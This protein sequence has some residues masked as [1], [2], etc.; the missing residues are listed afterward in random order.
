MNLIFKSPEIFKGANEAV[1]LLYNSHIITNISQKAAEQCI[2]EI[3]RNASISV[4]EDDYVKASDVLFYEYETEDTEIVFN[5]KKTKE[6]GYVAVEFFD[7]RE[8]KKA[9][10]VISQNFELLG[11]TREKRRLTSFQSALRPAAGMLWVLL[12]GGV[13][14]WLAYREQNSPTTGKMPWYIYIFC[15][16]VKAAGYLP[17]AFITAVLLVICFEWMFKRLAKPV[18]NI[19]A[20]R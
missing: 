12:S 19:S 15:E 10:K 5:F 16:I 13:L 17:F 8:L 2:E 6:V 4:S 3:N 18:F 9:E 7:Y 14:T 20:Y 11:F 1:V